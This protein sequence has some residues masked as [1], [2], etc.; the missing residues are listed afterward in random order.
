MARRLA[1]FPSNRVSANIQF[2]SRMAEAIPA[3]IWRTLAVAAL[4]V[5]AAG[6]APVLAAEAARSGVG[7]P[8]DSAPIVR[9]GSSEPTPAAAVAPPQTT[10]AADPWPPGSSAALVPSGSRPAP[11]CNAQSIVADPAPAGE[12]DAVCVAPDLE[13]DQ[14]YL[15]ETASPGGTMLHQGPALA[16]ARLHPVFVCRLAEAL[17]EARATGLPSAGISSAYRPPAFGVGG[18]SN[19]FN[20]LHTYGLAVDMLGIGGPGSSEAKLWH[21]IAARHGIV[22]PYGSDNRREWNH[23]QPTRVKII[24]ADNPLRG[25]VS[26]QGPVDLEAMFAVGDAMVSGADAGASSSAPQ[27]ASDQAGLSRAQGQPRP[28]GSAGRKESTATGDAK[29]DRS[30][31]SHPLLKSIAGSIANLRIRRLT[32]ARH[33]PQAGPSWCRHVHN[34]RRDLCGLVA[35]NARL[36]SGPAKKYRSLSLVRREIRLH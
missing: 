29:V 30:H 1:P 17:R 27:P 22:C 8:P 12:T 33:D 20:S 4:L 26:P 9:P 24:L 31:E 15:V 36:K 14:A 7:A 21:E 34:P 23:C 5:T 13:R 32:S 28:Q 10:T 2:V 11:G 25:T 35:E 16:I 3:I 6:P 19:K 18:F